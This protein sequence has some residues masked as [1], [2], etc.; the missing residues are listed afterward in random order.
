LSKSGWAGCFRLPICRD[1]E[2]SDLTSVRAA[3]EIRAS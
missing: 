2:I 3:K 1:E